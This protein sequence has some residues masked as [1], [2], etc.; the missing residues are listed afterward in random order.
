[1]KQAESNNIKI[2][3]KKLDEACLIEFGTRVVNKKDG[4]SIYPVYGGGGA[5]FKMD[6]YN[7]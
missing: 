4:G 7:R 6:T 3:S 5:T 1:M 2:I